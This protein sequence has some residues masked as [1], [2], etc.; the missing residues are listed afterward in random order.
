M[1]TTIIEQLN[2]KGFSLV[3]PKGNSMAPLFKEGKCTVEI[4]RL[5][6]K[7]KKNDLLVFSMDEKVVLHR[8]VKCTDDGWFTMG[9]NMLTGEFVKNEDIIGVVTAFYK[10][11][12]W[13]DIDSLD[14]KIYSRILF[15]LRPLRKAI[16]G[17]KE[18]LK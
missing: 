8:V 16:Q 14:F 6:R 2:E 4:H 5:M 13:H 11:G 17:A 18:K 1:K 9:D 7:P 10:D 15:T 12:K 3:N